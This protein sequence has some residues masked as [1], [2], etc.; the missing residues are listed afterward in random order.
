MTIALISQIHIG[1]TNVKINEGDTIENLY[2]S[3]CKVLVT[4]VRFKLNPNFIDRFRK[5]LQ[6]IKFHENLSSGN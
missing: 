2:W 4:L 5:N 6:N 1:M 3:S